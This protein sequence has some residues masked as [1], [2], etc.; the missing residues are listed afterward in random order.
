MSPK[1]MLSILKV[2]NPSKAPDID[3]L[4]GKLLEDGPQ[5][6]AQP[7]SQLCNL[8]TKLNSFPRKCKIAKIKPLFKKDCETGPQC[9]HPIL[10]LP[11]IKNY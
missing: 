10:L 3:N 9:Y 11:I 7:I 4:S 5:V 8:S 2:L 1:E 6:L